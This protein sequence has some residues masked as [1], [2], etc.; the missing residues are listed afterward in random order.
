[1]PYL[2]FLASTVP[3]HGGGPKI[4]KVVHVTISRPA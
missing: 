1:M 4:S 2:K 3:R